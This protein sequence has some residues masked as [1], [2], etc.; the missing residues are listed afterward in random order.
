M[1][2]NTLQKLGGTQPAQLK[3]RNT[4]IEA[5]MP[6]DENASNQPKVVRGKFYAKVRPQPLSNAK[7]VCY[8]KP[9]LDWLGMK[10]P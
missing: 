8:S 7:L 10:E 6:V 4:V 5:D 3:F 9:C 1:V 2:I